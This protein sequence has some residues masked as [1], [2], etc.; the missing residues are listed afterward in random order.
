MLSLPEI[1][2]GHHSCFFVLWRIP[3]E[4]LF[5]ELIILLRELEGGVGIV[6]WRVSML[7]LGL[8]DL[9]SCLGRAS[10]WFGRPTTWRAS[11]ATLAL[12]VKDRHWARG[13]IRACRKAERDMNGVIFDAMIAVGERNG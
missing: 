5:D 8:L 2:D 9:A 6:F 11:L 1:Q 3:L 7:K 13:A 10:T 4:D 12:A